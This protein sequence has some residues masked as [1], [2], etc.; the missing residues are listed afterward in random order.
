MERKKTAEKKGKLTEVIILPEGVNGEIE[1]NEIILKK[2]G[3]ESRKKVD[4]LKIKLSKREREI[5]IESDRQTKRERRMIGTIKAHI[6]N[7]LNGLDKKFV[8][9]MEICYL[10]FP[11]TVTIDKEKG[12]I[13]IK[14]FLGE[15]KPR[16]AKILQNVDVKVEKN[17]IVVESH[18]KEA[19]GQTAANIEKTT[20]IK[21]RDRKK[22]QDGIFM[23][24][25]CG[26]A[27]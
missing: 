22:F 17:I 4:L 13:V 24:E 11:M 19:A 16:I 21:N 12:E 27:I 8:Y 20:K 6:L 15:N 18:D 23:T 1:G 14:N 7:M 25:K 2:D 10:H 5:I 9:K 26:E 3:L